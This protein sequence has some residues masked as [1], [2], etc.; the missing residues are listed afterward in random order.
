MVRVDKKGFKKIDNMYATEHNE[1]S[2][3][4]HL[5]RDIQKQKMT[6]LKQ[7]MVLCGDLKDGK[8]TSLA[9]G[10]DPGVSM[11]CHSRVT[12]H[13]ALFYFKMVIILS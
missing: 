9:S 2:N 4:I 8:I 3:G 7:M 5:N 10:A 11:P 1:R 12:R 13:T 6:I